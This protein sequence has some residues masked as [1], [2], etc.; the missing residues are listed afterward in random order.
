MIHDDP[1]RLPV[2]S[3]LRERLSSNDDYSQLWQETL[4]TRT[5]QV[6]LSI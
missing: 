6:H 3:S 2:I 4:Q 1:Y 5:P